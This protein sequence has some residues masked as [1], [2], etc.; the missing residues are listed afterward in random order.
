M[1]LAP[2]QAVNDL[3]TVVN[4]GP[5][6]YDISGATVCCASKRRSTQTVQ[7]RRSTQTVQSE[8]AKMAL[9]H[10]CGLILGTSSTLGPEWDAEG[11][12]PSTT[13]DSAYSSDN[14]HD[15]SANQIPFFSLAMGR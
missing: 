5:G 8:G 10:I 3:S 2:K 1:S 15:S 14:E 11:V 7:S 12:P 9:N 4:L 13:L 6:T